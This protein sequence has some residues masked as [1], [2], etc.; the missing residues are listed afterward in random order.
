MQRAQRLAASAV[1]RVLAGRNLNA[2]LSE[3]GGGEGSDRSDRA[4]V[5]ELSFGSL[6][7]LGFLREALRLLARRPP[8]AEVESLLW[9]ALYQLAHTRAPAHA[10]VDQ[11][12]SACTA[13]G[14]ASAAGFVNAILRRFLRER[15][16]ITTAALATPEGRWS[17]P[18]WWIERVRAEYPAHWQA[19]LEAGNSRPPLVLR[20]NLGRTRVD[21][22][23]S[24]L[25]AAG[26]A[27]RPVGAQ[28]LLVEQPVPVGELPGFEEG[29]FS[30][31]DAGAQLA[32]PLLSPQGCRVLD[33]CAAPGGKTTHLAELGTAGL[34]ALDADPDRLGRVR[35]NLVRLGLDAEVQ[36]GDARDP[37]AWWNGVPF[38][39]I[40]A[41]VPC[42]ASGVVRRHP[43]IKWLRRPEDLASFAVQQGAI[44]D[45]LWRC[46]RPGGLLLYATCSIFREE[47]EDQVATF[48]ARHADVSREAI[49]L[50]DSPGRV[51]AR[52]LPG[53]WGPAHNHDGFF[54]ALLR[55]R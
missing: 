6:R 16:E 18:R 11:A 4:L 48:L 25:E 10:V 46:V 36:A 5:Q 29:L 47:N 33:A 55:K 23:R 52:L 35:E 49:T 40:L 20:V 50:P 14:K 9:I 51:G 17:H 21:D 53:D 19:I 37:A 13:L 28:A 24:R 43:D 26:V 44:L 42:S 22:F 12:V 39:R 41:D 15:N 34:L 54:H 27:A 31:Q 8:E 30:V 2:V 45:A 32:A 7:H 3:L 38:D 1:R